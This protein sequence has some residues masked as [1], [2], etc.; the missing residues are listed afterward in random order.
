MS[1]IQRI[2]IDSPED[3]RIFSVRPDIQ[4]AM[5]KHSKCSCNEELKSENQIIELSQ[6]I[7]TCE[8][9]VNII[10]RE[11]IELSQK[12]STCE[13]TVEKTSKEQ[14]LPSAIKEEKHNNCSDPTYAMVRAQFELHEGFLYPLVFKKD[15]LQKDSWKCFK[16]NT[17]SQSFEKHQI[18]MG[19]T[20]ELCAFY[21]KIIPSLIGHCIM[22]LYES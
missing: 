20:N 10:S 19:T 11:K 8:A 5:R 22:E 2:N 16:Y 18:T 9:T 3:W 13:A 15:Q 4:D 7:S 14:S 1:N 21:T 12:I 6:K 17:E